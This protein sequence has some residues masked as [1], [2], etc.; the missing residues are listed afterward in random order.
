MVDAEIQNFFNCMAGQ[1]YVYGLYYTFSDIY[2]KHMQIRQRVIF[3]ELHGEHPTWIRRRSTNSYINTL[4]LPGGGE[5]RAGHF[6]LSMIKFSGSF[7]R[8]SHEL[9]LTGLD[10]CLAQTCLQLE[11]SRT[12]T[13][14]RLHVQ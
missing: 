10:C 5:W 1:Q 6:P 7:R 8:C 9:R 13:E 2:G 11:P 12:E 14:N 4:T 3:V